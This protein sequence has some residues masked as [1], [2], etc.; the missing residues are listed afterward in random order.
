MRG[1]E[2]RT[3]AALA[4]SVLL[5]F[6]CGFLVYRTTGFVYAIADDVIMRDIASGAFTGTPDGHLIFMQYGLGW[7]ISRC[8]LLN[9]QVDWYGFFLA[10]ALFLALAAVLYRGLAADWSKKAKLCYSVCALGLF[11]TALVF[12]AAQFEWTISAAALAAAALYLYLSAETEKALS[13]TEQILIW[14]LLVLTYGIRYDV[15]F[16]ALPGFGIGFLWKTV[17]RQGGHLQFAWPQLLLP[18]LVFACVGGLFVTE[19]LAYSGTQWAEFQRFQTARSDVYDYYGVPSYEADPVFFEE[20]GLSDA[21]VRNLRHYA[22][23]LVDGMDA[24]R[25]ESLSAEAKLQSSRQTGIKARLK[26]GVILAAGQMRDLSYGTVSIPAVLVLAATLFL[27]ALYRKERLLPILLFVAAE[28]F[29]WLALGF[30]G[31]LPERVAISMHLVTLGGGAGFCV[32]LW[33]GLAD[34]GRKKKVFARSGAVL[35]LV[36]MAA[37]LWQWKDSIQSNR[38]KLSMDTSFQ[39][40]KNECKADTKSL[41]FIETYMAE[42]VG[43]AVVTAKGDFRLNRCLTLGDWYTTSPLDTERFEALDIQSVEQTL[44]ENP[45]AY[46]VVRDVADPGFLESYFTEKYPERELMLAETRETGGRLYYLYQ[47]AEK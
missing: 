14:L 36:L 7:L 6:I 32:E 15:F 16:M 13:G 27:A 17:K 38:E 34:E 23:Y 24:E 19:K 41:Y 26:N 33:Q 37:G 9:S 43:G 21:E 44:L 47:V 46:L 4:A 30:L 29:L 11:L 40:F 18:V 28:G 10:G 31:R 5:A 42:P 3:G 20:E 12:H 8:Y 1:M 22:L 45:H 35:G 25:M 2:K 39:Q